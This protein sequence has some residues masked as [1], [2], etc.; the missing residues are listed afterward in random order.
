MK[1]QIIF[2]AETASFLCKQMLETYLKVKGHFYTL[3]IN[4]LGNIVLVIN[5]NA[6][7]ELADILKE[8]SDYTIF[9]MSINKIELDTIYSNFIVSTSH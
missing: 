8:I 4:A 2:I 7:Y 9:S 5:I 1:Y 6:N 3:K